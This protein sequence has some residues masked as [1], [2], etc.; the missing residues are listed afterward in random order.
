MTIAETAFA[1]IDF[2][3][4]GARRGGTDTPVQLGIVGMR[5]LSPDPG[6]A[7]STFLF[8]D[9]PITWSAQRV[10]GICTEDLRA[11]PRFLDLWPEIRRLLAHRVIVAHGAATERRF[12]R[13][14]PLHGFGP[15]VDT[16]KLSRAVWPAQKSFALSDLIMAHDLEGDLAALHPKFRWHDAYSDALASLVLLRHIV[17]LCELGGQDSEILLHPDDSIYHRSKIR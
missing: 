16:L 8:T 17:S 15:W 9:Q 3:S 14:F 7:I 5:F 10:H 12:L 4:A 6:E 13:A 2:E 11:A 1:A